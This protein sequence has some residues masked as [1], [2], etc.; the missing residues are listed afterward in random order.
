MTVQGSDQDQI[1]HSGSSTVTLTFIANYEVDP[2][3]I[4]LRYNDLRSQLVP[5]IVDGTDRPQEILGTTDDAL[6][7]M[8]ETIREV[9]NSDA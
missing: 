6:E 5:A 8:R 3:E 1:D 4:D 2:D 9:K 7:D